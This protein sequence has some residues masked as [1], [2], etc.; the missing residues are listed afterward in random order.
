MRASS[1]DEGGSMMVGLDV[2]STMGCIPVLGVSEYAYSV[3][4]SRLI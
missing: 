2:L 3:P 4:N 1:L